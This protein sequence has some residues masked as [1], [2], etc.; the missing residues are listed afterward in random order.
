MFDIKMLCRALKTG[1]YDI[2]WYGFKLGQ[3][4]KSILMTNE[5]GYRVVHV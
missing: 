1:F 4:I 2:L 5:I 3:K